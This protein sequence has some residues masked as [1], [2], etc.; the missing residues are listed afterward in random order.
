MNAR[1]AYVTF[2]IR[3]P[4][5]VGEPCVSSRFHPGA[6]PLCAAMVASRS[7]CSA[8]ASRSRPASIPTCTRQPVMRTTF[9]RNDP[10]SSPGATAK[11]LFCRDFSGS[12]GRGSG[13]RR[14][15]GRGAIGGRRL[16]LEQLQRGE[17]TERLGE[18]RATI[19][20]SARGPLPSRI[21]P[22]PSA[23]CASPC[24]RRRPR[25]GSRAAPPRAGRCASPAR[26]RFWVL[27]TWR[28][29]GG[30]PP[31]GRWPR[32]PGSWGGRSLLVCARRS[33]QAPN[34]EEMMLPFG[35]NICKDAA[36]SSER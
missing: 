8:P 17:T 24:P 13:R 20:S 4:A 10:D 1:Y 22:R 12:F 18:H 29:C 25:D 19:A 32:R 5:V 30:W 9:R 21:S 16:R 31:L 14:E 15:R 3:G 6:R 2:S 23:A 36:T 26:R 33:R 28:R 34:S 11:R 7:G 35:R 27:A